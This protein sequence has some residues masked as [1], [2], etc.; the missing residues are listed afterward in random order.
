MPTLAPFRPEDK[1]VVCMRF[2]CMCVSARPCLRYTALTCQRLFASRVGRVIPV[3]NNA[4]F[5]RTRP[6]TRSIGWISSACRARQ[7]SSRSGLGSTKRQALWGA[8]GGPGKADATSDWTPIFNT[9]SNA[10]GVFLL[11]CKDVWF[12]LYSFCVEF[13]ASVFLRPR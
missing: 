2:V 7:I 4:F 5:R 3:Y 10:G 9:Y 12:R 8:A 13:I 6:K 1:F 11:L